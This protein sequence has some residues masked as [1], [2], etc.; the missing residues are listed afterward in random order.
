MEA[1][2]VAGVTKLSLYINT[3]SYS[4]TLTT[5]HIHNYFEAVQLL[6]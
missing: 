2:S 6:C 1:S 4:V 3:F 5:L